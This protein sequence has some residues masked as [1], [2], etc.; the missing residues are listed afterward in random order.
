MSRE[1]LFLVP[2]P[3]AHA[4]S[5]NRYKETTRVMARKNTN[6]VVARSDDPV[7]CDMEACVRRLAKEALELQRTGAEYPVL[8]T[9]EIFVRLKYS[10]TNGVK[11]IKRDFLT[12]QDY[13]VFIDP[14]SPMLLYFLYSSERF[15]VFFFI[16]HALQD[17]SITMANP[18]RIHMKY[19]PF[20]RFICKSH[21]KYRS[22]MEP[23]GKELLAN[24][25]R[26]TTTTTTT[27][28]EDDGNESEAEPESEPE[29]ESESEPESESGDLEIVSVHNHAPKSSPQITEASIAAMMDKLAEEAHKVQ[30]ANPK[31]QFPIGVSAKTAQAL[32]WKD[33][34]RKLL[35]KVQGSDDLVED[36]DYQ[37]CVLENRGVALR[38]R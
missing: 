25:E 29:S 1:W 26:A 18:A 14:P 23:L 9:P 16:H 21:G 22:F 2:A 7:K 19:E 13:K 12:P 36:R 20:L 30:A 4:S 15:V 28:S 27:D 38:R 10:G 8:L 37:V 3:P 35:Y 34:Y 5:F 17:I 6:A 31:C 11:Q 24:A 33:D 32:G